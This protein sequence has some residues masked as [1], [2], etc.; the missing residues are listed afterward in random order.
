MSTTIKKIVLTVAAFILVEFAVFLFNQTMQIV[1]AA[2]SVNPVF[3]P[4]VMWALIFLYAALLTTPFV[5]WFRLPKRML[6]PTA[7]EGAEYEAFLGEFK[8]RLAAIRGCGE[9]VWIRR[10][11]SRARWRFSTGMLTPS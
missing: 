5:L 3:G 7:T 11:R 1:Q 9:C 2:R 8:R 10:R 4:A 6:P